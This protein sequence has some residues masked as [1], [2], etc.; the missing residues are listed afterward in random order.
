MM[1]LYC[2]GKVIPKVGIPE[3]LSGYACMVSQ[4]DPEDIAE[5]NSEV[6][7]QEDG[8]FFAVRD[9]DQ[10]MDATALWSEAMRLGDDSTLAR[11][12]DEIYRHPSIEFVAV[13]F[14]DGGI[15]TVVSD[16]ASHCVS[17]IKKLFRKP[18]D[19]IGNPLF[20]WKS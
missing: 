16:E 7:S 10:G 14:V 20:L 12:I 9:N 13:A 17:E 4:P 18:W 8:E 2:F 6:G 3:L 5:L 19:T 11:I 15:E 1:S